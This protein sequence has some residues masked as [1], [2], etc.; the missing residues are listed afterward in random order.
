MWADSRAIAL[1][2]YLWSA[3]LSALPRSKNGRLSDQ[4]RGAGLGFKYDGGVG[5]GPRSRATGRPHRLPPL[6]K[7]NNLQQLQPTGFMVS[8]FPV[9]IERASAGWAGSRHIG[10][11][12]SYFLCAKRL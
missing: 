9:K 6:G 1:L 10:L 5:G 12:L 8:C 4:N 2:I 7:L 3:A 11:K